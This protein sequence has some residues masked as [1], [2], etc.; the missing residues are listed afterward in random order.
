MLRK[1]DT[2]LPVI[3]DRSRV[4]LSAQGF[5]VLIGDGIPPGVGL[6]HLLLLLPEGLGQQISGL[7]RH[8]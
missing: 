3:L 6:P 7:I 2:R 4:Q 1:G 8:G 5:E